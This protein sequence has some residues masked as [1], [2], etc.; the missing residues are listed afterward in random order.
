MDGDPYLV[1]VWHGKVETC[2]CGASGLV[3]YF[4]ENTILLTF[5]NLLC[6]MFKTLTLY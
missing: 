1:I 4:T 5:S 3:K 2:A 6:I